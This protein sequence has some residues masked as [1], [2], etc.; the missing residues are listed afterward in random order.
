MIR[1]P[2]RHEGPPRR[3]KQTTIATTS[4]AFGA[5]KGGYAI[6]HNISLRKPRVHVNFQRTHVSK[7]TYDR[8]K[9][10]TAAASYEESLC[11]CCFVIW[12]ELETLFYPS[13]WSSNRVPKWV[14]TVGSGILNITPHRPQR[15]QA[16]LWGCR[17]RGWAD[18]KNRLKWISH[19]RPP[20]VCLL[21]SHLD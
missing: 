11:S 15:N 21:Y 14:R 17:H 1:S 5:E 20:L 3:P 8:S 19:T 4:L 6:R 18:S 7:K 10:Q 9:C 2:R 13:V 16:K 12:Q